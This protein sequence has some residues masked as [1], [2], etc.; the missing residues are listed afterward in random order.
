MIVALHVRLISQNQN[1]K[2]QAAT[3]YLKT[4]VVDENLN[5]FMADSH[6]SQLSLLGAHPKTKI[7]RKI[8]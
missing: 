3:I 2:I 7:S 1:P 5:P 8:N 6:F 4:G